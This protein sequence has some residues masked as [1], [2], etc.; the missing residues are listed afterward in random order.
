[1][2]LRYRRIYFA[3]MII[4]FCLLST[5][6][7]GYSLGWRYDLDTY[8]L[9]KVGSIT[10]STDPRGADIYVDDVVFKKKAPATINNL[11]AQ[12]Y[13]ITITKEGYYDWH[14]NVTAHQDKV[15]RI[16]QIS[17]LRIVDP[18]HIDVTGTF[19]S[20]TVSPSGVFVII[21][22]TDQLSL[23]AATETIPRWSIVIDDMPIRQQWSLNEQYLMIQNADGDVTVISVNTGASM[24]LSE[25]TP[26][27]LVDPQWSNTEAD[28][29]YAHADGNIFRINIFQRTVTP[30]PTPLALTYHTDSLYVHRDQQSFE[31]YDA[32]F[33]LQ[34]TL[35][36]P[37]ERTVTIN[38]T[39]PNTYLIIDS[40]QETLYAYNPIRGI[41]EQAPG[42]T[43]EAVWDDTM[44]NLLTTN[45]NE[46]WHLDINRGTRDLIIRTS[47]TIGRAHWLAGAEYIIYETSDGLNIIEVRGPERNQYS[48]PIPTLTSW[49]MRNSGKTTHIVG[50]EGMSRLRF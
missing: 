2:K 32:N 3:L 36:I 6:I 28:V 45:A 13:R 46:I 9:K 5:G 16:P 23:Y 4:I 21:Q 48:I 50:E 7:I 47:E 38:T 22:S 24:P 40:D 49:G 30:I 34:T 19:E 39:N 33:T 10:V 31:L 20:V 8:Q 43:T 25:I 42:R 26:L 18:K 37:A 27:S 14:L 15:T 17:L 29:L 1:M 41:A 11:L 12:T 35:P 44:D